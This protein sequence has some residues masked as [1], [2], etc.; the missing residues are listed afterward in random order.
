MTRRHYSDE[1]RATALAVLTA[2]GGN[3]T[4]S[5]REVGVS[6]KTLA[7]WR[8]N[9]N[10][11]AP[12]DLRHEKVDDLLAM[13][14]RI[15]AK[16]GALTDATL[17]IAVPDVKRLDAFTRTS[18]IATDKAQLLG[19]GPTERVETIEVVIDLAED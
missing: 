3:V 6:R 17:D 13:W 4:R 1:E 8:D 16:A 11:A 12:A 14:R 19:G 10:G 7:Y 9:P 18:G 5:A 15:A 2:N